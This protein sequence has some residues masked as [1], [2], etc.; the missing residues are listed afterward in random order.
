MDACTMTDRIKLKGLE[1]GFSRVGVIPCHDFPDYADEVASR[2]EYR[3][4]REKRGS[5]F[6]GCFPSRYFPQGKSIICATYGLGGIDYPEKLLR[7]IGRIYLARCYV[8]TAASM[9]GRRVAAMTEFLQS[10]GMEVY[11]NE[12]E[13]PARPAAFEAGI[14]SYGD[15][16]FVRTEEDGTF[17][18]VYTWLVDRELAYDAHP[19]Q[20]HCPEGCTACMDACPTG[21]ILSP[22]R[23]D[24]MRCILMCDLSVPMGPGMADLVGEH[25]HGCDVC[26][27]VCPRNHQVLH[28]PKRRDPFLEEIAERFD[29]ERLLMLAG[30]DDPYY[31]EVIQPIMYNYIRDVDVFRRNAAIAM[32]NSGDPAWIPALER[33]CVAF[34]GKPS[35]KAARWAMEKLSA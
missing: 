32:G 11:G 26:Q 2:P 6:E 28:G 7:Y 31:I 8:P 19:A 16:N 15:N 21:A 1:L 23:L 20:D 22:R 30:F 18:V 24:P 34:A 25:I 33:A 12:V 5:F 4:F 9:T 10:L 14:V 27:T 3:Y 29:L 17:V 13:F 35:A